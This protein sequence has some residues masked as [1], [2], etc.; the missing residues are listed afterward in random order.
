VKNVQRAEGWKAHHIHVMLRRTHGRHSCIRLLMLLMRMHALW[1]VQVQATGPC[2]PFFWIPM[3]WA[4][5]PAAVEE[6]A[7]FTGG[8]MTSRLQVECKPFLRAGSSET[9]LGWL[10]P[11][12][13]LTAGRSTG[14]GDSGDRVRLEV[15]RIMLKEEEPV[16]TSIVVGFEARHT[17]TNEA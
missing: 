12:H 14:L 8:R 1:V 6:R 13:R 15:E 7:D 11:E 10:H 4:A 3:H 17:R 2:N 5:L 9:E 16:S